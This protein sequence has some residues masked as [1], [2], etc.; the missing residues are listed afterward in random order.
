M[1]ANLLALQVR[2]KILEVETLVRQQ[3]EPFFPSRKP[4]E[5]IDYPDLI[6]GVVDCVAHAS[7]LTLSDILR[8]VSGAQPQ[9]T[10]LDSPPYDSGTLEQM[11]RRVGAAFNFVRG[12]SITA[13]KPLGFGLQQIQASSPGCGLDACTNLQVGDDSKTPSL[14]SRTRPPASKS[15]ME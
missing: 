14:D 10:E 1:K 2:A 8:S 13:A 6:C 3:L 7:L 5:Q 15:E 9:H 4:A 12:K 11:T